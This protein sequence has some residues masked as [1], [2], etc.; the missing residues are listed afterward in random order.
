MCVFGKPNMPTPAAQL[1]PATGNGE[2]QRQADMEDALRRRRA[3]AAANV[4]T[5]P[6]GIPSRAATARLGGVAAQ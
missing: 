5:G 3:G 1:I 4:L 2:A 6:G